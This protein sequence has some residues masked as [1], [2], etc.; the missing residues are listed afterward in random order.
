MTLKLPDVTIVA[1]DT[2]AA[3]LLRLALA[4]TLRQIEPA[5]V[6]VWSNTDPLL[7]GVEH[8]EIGRLSS[9]DDYSAILWYMVPWKVKTSHFLVMQW[10]G[11]VLDA[12]RWN[13][14]FL[15]YDYI[16]AVWPWFGSSRVGNGGFSLRSKRLARRVGEQEWRMPPHADEDKVLCR[17]YRYE[18]DRDGEFLWAPE[19]L[20]R[21]FSHECESPPPG[22]TFGFHDCRNFPAV[23]DPEH[24]D[25]RISLASEYVKQ[26]QRFR[27][28]VW[29]YRV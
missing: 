10:D 26:K 14:E 3:A 4:D 29:P 21:Q 17:Q 9:L 23:M 8:V 18:L 24:L 12:S 16:G 22:G 27:D 7:P 5:R 20:A 6:V 15:E 1:I 11:W 19:A 25:E 2:D 28:M 13:P